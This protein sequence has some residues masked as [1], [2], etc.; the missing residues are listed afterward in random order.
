MKSTGMEILAFMDC[1]VYS[2]V[3]WDCN[4]VLFVLSVRYGVC[5]ESPHT[6]RNV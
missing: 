6:L 4:A 1:D 3:V 5:E 2:Y